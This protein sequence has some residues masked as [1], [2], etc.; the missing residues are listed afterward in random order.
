MIHLNWLNTHK[1]ENRKSGSKRGR[2]S[3]HEWALKRSEEIVF[4]YALKHFSSA[5]NLNIAHGSAS[6]VHLASLLLSFVVHTGW[7]AANQS[8]KI[9]DQLLGTSI[10]EFF[11][12]TLDKLSRYQISQL[13]QWKAAREMRN[14]LHLC[15]G[16]LCL[17]KTWAQRYQ[18]AFVL[19]PQQWK[20]PFD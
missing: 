6:W 10:F 8:W 11:I 4:I 16:R 12:D 19:L 1:V 7:L 2:G 15:G 5:T 20:R 9:R 14:R 17:C 3:I 18:L 13:S